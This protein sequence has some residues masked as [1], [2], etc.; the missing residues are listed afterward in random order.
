MKKLTY[1][2]QG[3]YLIPDLEVPEKANGLGRFGM[4]RRKFLREKKDGIYTGMLLTGKLEAHLQEIDQEATE[5]MEELTKKMAKLEGVTEKLKGE[6]QMRWVQLMNN[7]RHSAE[8]TVLNE[9]VYR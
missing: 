6:D 9:L 1:T 3:D 4:L 2:K 7:I 8:E 5:M